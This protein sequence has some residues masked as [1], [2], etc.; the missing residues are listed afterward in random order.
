M[1]H[2][3]CTKKQSERA[4][5]GGGEVDKKRERKLKMEERKGI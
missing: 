2:L 1:V 5:K 4:S 3:W